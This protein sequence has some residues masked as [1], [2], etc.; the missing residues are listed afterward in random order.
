MDRFF[1][2]AAQWTPEVLHLGGEE[3]HHAVRVMRKKVGDLVEVFDGAGRWARGEVQGAGKSSLEVRIDEEGTQAPSSPALELAVA[4]PK[5]KTMDWIVQKAVELGVSRIQPL[6]TT[7]TVVKPGSGKDDKWQ[8]I[9]LEACKQ[10][11]QNHLPLVAQPLNY[12]QWLSQ[13]MGGIKVIAS[14]AGETKT[15]REVLS[16]QEGDG[17]YIFLVGP[18]GDFTADEVSRALAQ[19][20]HPV[21]LGGIVLRVETA[22]LY[23]LAAARCLLT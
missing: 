4:I 9:A 8:R 2:A 19:G 12:E 7:H 20:F 5:G 15:L 22:C 23:L 3:G 17:K 16:A 21:T 11:G 18:E 10:C 14:L 13:P 6:V 1:L